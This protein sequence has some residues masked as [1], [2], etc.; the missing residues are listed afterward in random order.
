MHH[1]RVPNTIDTPLSCP[2]LMVTET[3]LQRCLTEMF[4][5]HLN[6]FFPD[7]PEA[8]SNS[9]SSSTSS[10]VTFTSTTPSSFS[11]TTLQS[12]TPKSTELFSP[13]PKA[14]VVATPSNASTEG[15]S[16]DTN[17]T[18]LTKPKEDLPHPLADSAIDEG[19]TVVLDGTGCSSPKP[20][21]R[22]ASSPAPP[23]TVRTRSLPRSGPPPIP[24]P[25]TSSS[26]NL[27]PPESPPFPHRT[28]PSTAPRTRQGT[29]S[30]SSG[31]G[32]GHSG[33]TPTEN[34]VS[35]NGRS[36]A[37]PDTP[38]VRY[39]MTSQHIVCH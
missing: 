7:L 39:S 31:T 18:T 26:N 25:R 13:P 36:E 20:F 28:P 10:P 4:I 1:V 3:T 34:R 21:Q 2:R 9:K 29:G 24:A 15:I 23:D 5:E 38:P 27:T 14:G 8:L 17:N 19:V 33:E 37:A 22:S 16:K 11:P 30:V 32:S 12:Y 35:E 6:Y